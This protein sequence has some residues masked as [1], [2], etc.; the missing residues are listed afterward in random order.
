MRTHPFRFLANTILYLLFLCITALLALEATLGTFHQLDSRGHLE[1]PLKHYYTRYLRHVDLTTRNI[2]QYQSDCA[3]YDELLFYRLRPGTCVFKNTEFDTTVQV[4]GLGL[5]DDEI[6]LQ[7]PKVIFLGDSY[8]MGWGVQQNETFPQ[9]FERI[10]GLRTLNGGISS[11]GTVREMRLLKKIDRNQAQ[12]VFIQYNGNDSRE[13]EV[14]LKNGFLEISEQEKYHK[15]I[16]A[17]KEGRAYHW[18]RYSKT[19]F[20][21]M[22]LKI[23]SKLKSL[24]SKNNAPIATNTDAKYFINV[25]K[26]S[27]LDHS[28]PKIIVFDVGDHNKNDPKFIDD[29]SVLL[30]GSS[31]DNLVSTID[32]SSIL[33][34]E[35]YFRLDAHINDKG[36]RKIA[37]F[38]SDAFFRKRSSEGIELP[39]SQAHN[40]G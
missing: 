21:I 2:I 33:N 29:L 9:V 39:S 22:K 31:L 30:K 20:K 8:T 16:Q 6:S 36:H 25:L 3:Q 15:L 19:F 1:G 34:Q 38:L 5:R 13:N 4:N 17:H 7:S 23:A 14:F 40:E 10:T 11:Y 27:D 35:D 26:K 32:I 24:S 12:Y 18:G 28:G 37:R